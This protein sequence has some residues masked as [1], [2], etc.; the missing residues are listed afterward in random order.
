MDRIEKYQNVIISFLK[1]YID[2]T[3]NKVEGRTES[4]L[5]RILIDKEN[6]SF[7]LLSTGWQGAH[8]I[9]GT[10]FHFDI[11]NEKIWIQCNNTEWEVVDE[12]I[13]QGINKQDIVL[14]FIPPHARHFSGFATA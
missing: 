10:I 1:H 12:F 13:A 8:Y 2:E 11:I 5:R 4:D 7:Q 3:T 9:F 6:N 14:G